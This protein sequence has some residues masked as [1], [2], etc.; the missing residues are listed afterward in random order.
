MRFF[1]VELMPSFT[2]GMLKSFWPFLSLATT[3]TMVWAPPWL[4]SFTVPG[5]DFST[6]SRN[7]GGA[8]ASAE[9][10]TKPRSPPRCADSGSSE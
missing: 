4:T 1:N 9:I 6:A 7:A 2:S 5:F 3:S 8:C 10:G